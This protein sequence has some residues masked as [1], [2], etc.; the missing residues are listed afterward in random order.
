[1]D[2]GTKIKELRMKNALTLEELAARSELSKGFLSQLERNLTSPSIATLDDILE[3]LGS[4]LGEF[5]KESK[6]T[7][8][9]F[10]Q[11]DYYINE[12]DGVTMK[13]IVPNAQ[14]NDMEPILLHLDIGATSDVIEPHDGEEFAYVVKGRIRLINGGN[15]AYLSKGDTFYLDGKHTHLVQQVGSEKAEVIWVIS[16]PNF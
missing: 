15:E 4:S 13:F 3:V 11:E 6:N 16:P 9:V 2:I 14:K 5:F 10:T 12:K 1:M 8:V 7:K